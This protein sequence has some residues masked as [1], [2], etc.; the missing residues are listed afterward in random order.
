MPVYSYKGVAATG[1]AARGFVDAENLRAARAKLRREGV[2]LTEIREGGGAQ[3]SGARARP[4]RQISLE[5][6]RGN[7][8]RAA[9]FLGFNRN[10]LR[11]KINDLRIVVRRGPAA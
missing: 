5:R 1:K 7:Q 6:F 10:T 8:V 9:R 11:K 3:E 2:V 4:S